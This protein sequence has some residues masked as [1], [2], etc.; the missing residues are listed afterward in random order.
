LIHLTDLIFRRWVVWVLRFHDHI[1]FIVYFWFY[2]FFAGF[3]MVFERNSLMINE[4]RFS[5]SLR[6]KLW[7]LKGMYAFAGSF[8]VRCGTQWGAQGT[9]TINAMMLRE[10]VY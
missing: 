7:L 4:I 6:V 3:F 8:L 5:G 10:I 2:R 1:W 9:V